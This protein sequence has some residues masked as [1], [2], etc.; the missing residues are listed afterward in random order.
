MRKFNIDECKVGM[1][2]CYE[3]M[4]SPCDKTYAKITNI[5]YDHGKNSDKI[6]AVNTRDWENDEW[7]VIFKNSFRGDI[8]NNNNNNI[9]TKWYFCDK[10]E[11]PKKGI[12]KILEQFV[13]GLKYLLGIHKIN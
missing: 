6:Y 8:Y 13:V 2:V 3:P 4:D 9:K 12:A 7:G 11:L 1:F 5:V 10:R